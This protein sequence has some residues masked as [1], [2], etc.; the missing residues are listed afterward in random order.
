LPIRRWVNLLQSYIGV[1][2]LKLCDLFIHCYLINDSET[3]FICSH[4]IHFPMIY[5]FFSSI[6]CPSILIFLFPAKCN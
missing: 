2:V 3:S 5:L 6:N 1:C 4:S